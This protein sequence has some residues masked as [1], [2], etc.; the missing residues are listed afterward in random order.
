MI[1]ANEYDFVQAVSGTHE[2][3]Q[4][5]CVVSLQ[6]QRQ[7]ADGNIKD[8]DDEFVT[9]KPV[10]QMFKQAGGYVLVDFVF[11]SIYDVELNRM[12]SY[13]QQFF[14]A[15]NSTDDDELD[16]PM[17]VVTFVP[18]EHD[19]EY[20]ALGIN[21]IFHALVPE[22]TKGDPTIIRLLFTAHVDP[23]LVPNFLFLKSNNEM[24]DKFMNDDSE[25]DSEDVLVS[26]G[27]V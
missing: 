19:G 26:D 16:F 23:D 7:D 3:G 27:S 11:D 25:S 20:F 8:V 21:P 14:Q 5:K 15:S 13:V 17:L 18:K 9:E 12:Y 1:I 24:L 4:G 2:H 22:D 10:V 6:A